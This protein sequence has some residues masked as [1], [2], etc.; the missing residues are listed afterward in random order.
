[1][2]SRGGTQDAA[3]LFRSFRGRD[4]SVEPLLTER[5]LK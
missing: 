5:G 3:D 2:L 4:P 1:V